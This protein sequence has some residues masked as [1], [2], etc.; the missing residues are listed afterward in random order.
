MREFTDPGSMIIL[1]AKSPDDYR[2][3][4]LEELL[5]QSFGPEYL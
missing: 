4:T 3:Y 5:P 1:S 2:E